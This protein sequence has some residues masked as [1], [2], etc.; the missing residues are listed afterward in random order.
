MTTGSACGSEYPERTRVGRGGDQV[1]LGR[2][3]CQSAKHHPQYRQQGDKTMIP[4]TKQ[5]PRK[6]LQRWLLRLPIWLYHARLG[7]LLRERFLLLTHV[8]RKSGLSRQTVVEVVHHDAATD[9]YF[10]ASGWGETPDWL[11]NLQKTPNVRVNVGRRHFE[12][13]AACLPLSQ[14]Q[15]V[16]LH[17]AR[18]HS[19][20]FQALTKLM[21]GQRLQPIEEDCLTLAQSVPVVALRPRLRGV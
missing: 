3:V 18:H 15:S 20:A 7:W 6:G 16:L 4:L 17:Y 11:R 13:M 2:L 9:T 21:I 12:A 5:Q 1:A 19:L 10:I 14:A 8:G